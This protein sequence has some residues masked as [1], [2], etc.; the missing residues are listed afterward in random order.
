MSM[1]IVEGGIGRY[2]RLGRGGRKEVAHFR[3]KTVAS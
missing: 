1:E 3:Q 2:K